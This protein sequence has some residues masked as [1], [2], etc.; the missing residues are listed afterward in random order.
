MGFVISFMKVKIS[1]TREDSTSQFKYNA[2]LTAQHKNFIKLGL[3][4]KQYF[5]AR[6]N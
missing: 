4:N 6:K 2:I 1:K 5:L 3:A